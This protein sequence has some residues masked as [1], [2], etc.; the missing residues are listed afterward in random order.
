VCMST[1][2]IERP[3]DPCDSG[4]VRA[5]VQHQS[6]L[7]APVTSTFSPSSTNA[8]ARASSTALIAM[9]ARSDPASASV[10][11][12]HAVMEPPGAAGSVREEGGE[13][14]GGGGRE[15]PLALRGG[16]EF[17]HRRRHEHRGSVDEGRVVVRG[18]ETHDRLPA[19][20]PAAAAVL[21]GEAHAQVSRRAG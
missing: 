11:A 19:A 4:S 5:M 13:G 2:N 17:E 8:S 16:A 14:A 3:R 1:R 15:P 18:F 6:A 9:F 21:G 12:M 7:C 20:R 10:Y